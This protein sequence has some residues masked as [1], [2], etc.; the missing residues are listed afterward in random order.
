MDAAGR[1]RPATAAQLANLEVLATRTV[2]HRGARL[3]CRRIPAGS[4]VAKTGL[5]S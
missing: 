3:L 4:Q 2:T 5:R 1:G